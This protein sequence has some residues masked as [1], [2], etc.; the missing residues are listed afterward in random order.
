M[1]NRGVALTVVFSAR[2]ADFRSVYCVFSPLTT[3]LV[4]RLHPD[5]IHQISHLSEGLYSRRSVAGG[6]LSGNSNPINGLEGPAALDPP[7]MKP[8]R[9]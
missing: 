1:V 3:L 2:I 9:R 5:S 6:P 4:Q 8:T 7:P